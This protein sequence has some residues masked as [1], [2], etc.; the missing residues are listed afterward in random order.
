M[1]FASTILLVFVCVVVIQQGDALKQ[2]RKTSRSRMNDILRTKFS[3]TAG[4]P[5]IPTPGKITQPLDHFD[6]T[7]N[8]TWEQVCGILRN[9]FILF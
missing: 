5:R 1:R 6:V 7:N 9:T 2:F 8:K 4:T 3:E